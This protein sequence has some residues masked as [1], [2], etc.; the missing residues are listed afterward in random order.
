MTEPLYRSLTPILYK[1]PLYSVSI[2]LSTAAMHYRFIR[3]SVFGRIVYHLLSHKVFAH[4]E[5]LPGYVIPDKYLGE[6]SH[7]DGD[8][9]KES[10]NKVAT[11]EVARDSLSSEG[12]DHQIIVTWDGDDDEENP[13]NWPLHHKV[14]FIAEIGILTLTIYIGL[15]IYIPGIDEIKKQFHVSQTVATLPLT[16]FVFGYG[17]G[18]MLFSPL[19]ES[20]KFGRAYIYSITL[21]LFFIFQIPTALSTSIAE[22]CILRFISGLFASPA[23]ATG[24]ASV[25]DILAIPWMPIG[26]CAWAG[27]AV[28]G[29]SL[30]PLV[31]AA[32]VNAGGWK[33][34]FWFM[35]IASGVCF[36]ALTLFLPESSNKALLY[37][38]ATRLRKLTGNNNITSEGHI[39]IFK[40]S[41]HQALK[42]ILWRPFEII[43]FEPVALLI[44][45]YIGLV[46][47]IMYLWYEDFPI[48]YQ[49]IY[50]FTPVESGVAFMGLVIGVCIAVA[51]YLPVV[52]KIFTK[53]LLHGQPVVPEDML[54]ITIVA[55]ACMPLGLVIFAWTS[56]PD[57]HWIVPTIGAA[58]TSGASFIVFQT[59]FNYLSMSFY[60]YM[61]SVFAGNGLFR[62]I[63]GGAFP[64]FG[65]PL[66]LNL[67]TKNYPV[68]WGTMILFFLTLLMLLIPILFYV[69]GEKL[70][71]RS[72]Y[73]N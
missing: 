70:R 43:I 18:P 64:L 63:M 29:P 11:E 60:R 71:A 27:A 55:G 50:H 39:E 26:L 51:L 22:L 14:F 20:P 15:A 17:I 10:K 47:S 6:P 19:S 9:L 73:A 57:I 3:D 53:K 69:N 16:L 40:M 48:V 65:R 35:A 13:L 28:C 66:F 61:A 4:K 67:S 45:V 36:V 44:D 23:L 8:T 24:G 32:L 5:E 37:R 54:P 7:F 34:P 72:K 33:W 1:Y 41:F 46:Y 12:T 68:A 42:D 59:L 58:I 62:A 30:G 2:T 49:S 31:G 52:Y 38:K 21:L 56:K 25:G